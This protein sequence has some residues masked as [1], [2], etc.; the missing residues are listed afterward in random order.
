MKKRCLLAVL[1]VLVMLIS[2]C[3][4]QP[5]TQ[6]VVSEETV[7][8]AETVSS[9]GTD[10]HW[11]ATDGAELATEYVENDRLFAGMLDYLTTSFTGHDIANIGLIVVSSCQIDREKSTDSRYYWNVKGHFYGEDEYG[12]TDGVYDFE[13]TVYSDG[14]STTFNEWL[15]DKDSSSI[16]IKKS[17]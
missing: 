2:G 13:A 17:N 8:V 1:L 5:A 7:S 4:G 11:L 3:T 6:E 15:F 16:V 12:H 10:W 9:E 14:Y